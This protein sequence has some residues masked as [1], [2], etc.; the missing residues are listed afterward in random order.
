[1][2][3]VRRTGRAGHPAHFRLT[4]WANAAAVIAPCRLPFGWRRFAIGRFDLKRLTGGYLHP[5]HRVD[6]Q[7]SRNDDGP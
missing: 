7:G 2:S 5:N 6:F 3:E 1:M 4:G